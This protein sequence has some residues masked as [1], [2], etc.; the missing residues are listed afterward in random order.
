[1]KITKQFFIDAY[2][3]FVALLSITL[4]MHACGIICNLSGLFAFQTLGC[5][6][7]DVI[8]HINRTRIHW[9]KGS[10]RNII[11]TTC[12]FVIKNFVIQLIVFSHKFTWYTSMAAI[13][14]MGMS[15]TFLYSKENENKNV[16]CSMIQMHVIM[17]ALA[18]VGEFCLN[19]PVYRGFIDDFAILNSHEFRLVAA[20]LPLVFELFV[21]LSDF[22][23]KFHRGIKTSHREEY[24]GRDIMHMFAMII[25]SGLIYHYL[26]ESDIL[27]RFLVKKKVE[28]H[29]T[30]PVTALIGFFMN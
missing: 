16:K 14:I 10:L 27:D 18:W 3:C 12:L 19:S 11:M 20:F 23:K 2:D 13:A 1:M 8:N 21:K 28:V 7:T 15:D 5:L 17:M 4:L 22:Y 26:T 9:N 25:I 30:D 24:S 6:V 29:F